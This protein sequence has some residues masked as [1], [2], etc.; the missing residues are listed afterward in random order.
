MAES[1]R[2]KRVA[3]LV[4][5]VLSRD[6]IE[7]FQDSSSGLITISK[8]KMTPDLKTA[9]FYLTYIGEKI[10]KSILETL[11]KRRGSLRKSIASKIKLKYNPM[12]IFSLDESFDHIDRI[13]KV[14]KKL[15][16]NEK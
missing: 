9:Y 2:Q 7:F 15:D 10:D 3:S 1:I 16:E 8:V 4:K 6:L 12:L 5:E 13:Q 11:E 14:M